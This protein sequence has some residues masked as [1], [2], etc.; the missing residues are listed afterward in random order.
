MTQL[1]SLISNLIQAAG[2]RDEDVHYALLPLKLKAKEIKDERAKLVEALKA[3]TPKVI[4]AFGNEALKAL[5]GKSGISNYRSQPI[6]LHKDFENDST[7]VIATFHPYSLVREEK[8]RERILEDL[9]RYRRE[10]FGDFEKPPTPYIPFDLFTR[11]TNTGPDFKANLW[12][13]DIETS[14]W[15]TSEPL[16]DRPGF[17]VSYAQPSTNYKAPTFRI[18]SIG[19][20]DG[21]TV[22]IFEPPYIKL[23][24][25]M[26]SN[27]QKRGIQ[28][29]GHNATWYDRVVIEHLY[30][31]NI[32]CGDTMIMHF[33]LD[34][35]GRRTL[36]LLATRYLGVASWK[37]DGTYGRQYLARDCR[38][39]FLLAN[40]FL[41]EL[42][43]DPL[44]LTT[45]KHLLLPASRSLNKVRE[46]GVFVI[47]KNIDEA[48]ESIKA[49]R[50]RLRARLVEIAK[51]VGFEN[52]NPNSSPQLKKLLFDTWNVPIVRRTSA[53]APSADELSLKL[54]LEEAQLP[55]TPKEFLTTLL[56]YREN[57]QLQQYLDQY[58]KGRDSA[59]RVH[60]D[61]SLTFVVTGRTSTRR[62]KNSPWLGRGASIQ[63]LPNDP[64]V[65]RIIGAPEGRVLVIADLSQI[66]LRT[67]AFIARVKAWI[68][69]YR[70]DIDLHLLAASRITSKPLSEVTD[71]ERREAKPANFGFLYGAEP[72][73]FVNYAFKQYG[74]RFDMEQAE[75]IQA[76]FF[77]MA[78]ELIDYYNATW[79]EIKKFGYVRSPLGR[80]RHLP[81]AFS[82]NE[83]KRVEAL[84]EGINAKNQSFGSDILLI[85]LNLITGKEYM[86]VME[87]HDSF[88]VEVDDDPVIIQRAVADVRWALEKGTPEILRTVWGIDFDVPIK[89]DISVRKAWEK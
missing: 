20:D 19:I 40:L 48:E 41:R 80:R 2:L 84:R 78:P 55:P 18:D 45:Y 33:L 71:K 72:F 38:Y 87:V 79:E 24:V 61:Y 23:A 10:L 35:E 54:I 27:A 25:E 69:A 63:Q 51:E 73:T 60:S 65:R 85:G 16:E 8:F 58:R 66:E 86:V 82:D 13:F 76:K 21:T 88:A 30:G 1:Q 62:P 56:E 37:D 29:V 59:G 15:I 17:L 89:A 12:S 67:I 81:N 39:T 28:I 74:I 83:S 43:K 6:E 68:K 44:L 14:E 46:N 34:E 32:K 26:L 42:R 77:E 50:D 75:H 47:E 11:E 64:R 31:E 4:L 53:G 52:F 22:W 70:E 5:T 7:K 36:E 49:D 57:K 9:T 3:E